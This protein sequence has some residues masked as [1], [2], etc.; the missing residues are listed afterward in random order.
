MFVRI[1]TLKIPVLVA[2]LKNGGRDGKFKN[3]LGLK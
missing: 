1:V 2:I 3:S